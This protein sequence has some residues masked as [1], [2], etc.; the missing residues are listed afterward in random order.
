MNKK[1]VLAESIKY[2]LKMFLAVLTGGAVALLGFYYFVYSPL[3]DEIQSVLY[4]EVNRLVMENSDT[5]IESLTNEGELVIGI[6]LLLIGY[7]IYRI[8]KTY[9]IFSKRREYEGSTESTDS[10]NPDDSHG[11]D[12]ID[13]NTEENLKEDSGHPVLED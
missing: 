9:V 5:S 8:I 11:T 7:M 12:K 4:D 3:L 2:N 1:D 10:R 6:G 13:N